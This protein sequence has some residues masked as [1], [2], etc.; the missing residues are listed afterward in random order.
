MHELVPASAGAARTAIVLLAAAAALAGCTSGTRFQAS[1][2][3]ATPATPVQQTTLAP[4]EP[5]PTNEEPLDA[6]PAAEETEVAALPPE[7]TALEVSRNDLVGGWALSSGGETCQL[8]MSLTQWTGGYRASTRGCT[9]E[10]LSSISAWDLTGKTVTLKGG[11]G[12]TVATLLATGQQTF[13][14]SSAA[15]RAVTVS[16]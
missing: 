3:P 8:F 5:P 12:Q 9:G 14:G 10:A 13:S 4:V 7:E 2:L 11:E 6:E 16:R 1:P 15:G